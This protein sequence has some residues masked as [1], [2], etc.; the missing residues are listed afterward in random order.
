LE[1]EPL[2]DELMTVIAV[3]SDFTVHFTP[4]HV[5]S[6]EWERTTNRRG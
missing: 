6:Y 3:L 5:L 2:H 4:E 1:T